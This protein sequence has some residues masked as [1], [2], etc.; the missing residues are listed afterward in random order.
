MYRFTLF[1]LLIVVSTVL[2][3]A[4]SEDDDPV[5]PQQ[6]H[7][8]AEG[9]VFSNSGIELLRIFQ[10]TATGHFEVPHGALS[11]HIEVTFLDENENEIDPPSDTDKKLAWAIDDPSIVEVY[12]HE[13]EEGG[14]EFHLRGLEE[15]ETMIEFFIE[16]AGH[17]DYRSGKIEVHVED[18]AHSGEPHLIKIIDEESGNVLAEAHLA[19]ENETSGSLTVKAGETSDH[20]EVQFF[21]ESMER[22]Y[23]DTDHHSLD[24]E[25]GD[26]NLLG[27]V[28]P[29]A[30]EPWAFKITGKT[31]GSTTLQVLL[32]HEDHV[33]KRFTA[34]D[35]TI[36]N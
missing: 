8:E 1:T 22:V 23:P 12:Q 4:C 15:G 7:F 21:T 36:E 31:A 35:V 3:T 19:D 10:G 18:G 24:F 20:I 33:G 26:D 32:M 34:V 16:H 5:Q 27:V 11:D 28:P 25:I 6:E 2:F 9:M 13:G 14:Y 17:N 29:E 30:A